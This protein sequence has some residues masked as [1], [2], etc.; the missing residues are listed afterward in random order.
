MSQAEFASVQDGY[1]DQD[2]LLEN[3]TA[4]PMGITREAADGRAQAG[5]LSS[6]QFRMIAYNAATAMW[7]S[8][9]RDRARCCH[10]P[11]N[12]F[13]PRCL[14]VAT[15][16]TTFVIIVFVILR[17]AI[18][19]ALLKLRWHGAVGVTL[20][21]PNIDVGAVAA[22]YRVSATAIH[23][24]RISQGCLILRSE[25]T[26]RVAEPVT[27]TEIETVPARRRMRIDPVLR[28]KHEGFALARRVDGAAQLSNERGGGKAREH[29]L[30]FPS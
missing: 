10:H 24:P 13:T 7:G 22:W 9:Y 12:V 25:I 3:K 8:A 27:G 6:H 18:D 30:R 16:R 4:P 14:I 23:G 28:L 21:I 15:P 29:I 26:V 1:P 17:A 2:G 20:A 5:C 11:V 19:P